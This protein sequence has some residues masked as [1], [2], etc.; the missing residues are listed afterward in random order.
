MG[1][2]TL[3]DVRFLLDEGACE[4]AT[5]KCRRDVY[6][7]DLTGA[8]AQ[9]IVRLLQPADFR[10]SFGNCSTDF[11]D[12]DGDDY[13]LWCDLARKTRVAA[14]QGTKLYIKLAIHTNPDACLI[15]SFHESKPSW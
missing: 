3:E 14:G 9:E 7:L 11:G 12:V 6:E 8:D 5:F 15:I 2:Y 10:K 1:H 4:F 13:I